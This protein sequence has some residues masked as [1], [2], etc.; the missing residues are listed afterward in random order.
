MAYEKIHAFWEDSIFL[1]MNDNKMFDALFFDKNITKLL[2]QAAFDSYDTDGSQTITIHELSQWM[3]RHG[4]T[5]SQGTWF[6]IHG[7]GPM[8]GKIYQ[9]PLLKTDHS[10]YLFDGTNEHACGWIDNSQSSGSNKG[11]CQLLIIW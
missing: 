8:L 6:Y 11:E 9:T 5:M 2:F 7:I 4:K 1:M 10:G 3:Q